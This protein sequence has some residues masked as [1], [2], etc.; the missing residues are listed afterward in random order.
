MCSLQAPVRPVVSK[1]C[2]SK[3]LFSLE[4]ILDA[5]DENPTIFTD[6]SYY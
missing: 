4:Q 2:N 1:F 6:D 5:G 3:R